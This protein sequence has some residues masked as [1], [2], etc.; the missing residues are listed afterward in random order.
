MQR[1]YPFWLWQ[2]VAKRSEYHWLGGI[3]V[4]AGSPPGVPYDIGELR[5]PL[6]ASFGTII[7]AIPESNRAFEKVAGIAAAAARPGGKESLRRGW[8]HAT[9]RGSWRKLGI[10]TGGSHQRR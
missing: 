6:D 2:V 7:K 10:A 1:F 8:K 4:A 5:P 9:H 3:R